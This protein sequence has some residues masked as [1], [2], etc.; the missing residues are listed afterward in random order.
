MPIKLN[1]RTLQEKSQLISD[2]HDHSINYES[3]EIYM[4]S[5]FQEEEEGVDFRMCTKLVKNLN[6]LFHMSPTEPILIHQLT[7]GGD[8]NYGMAMYD[9]IKSCS[10]SITVL[11][12]GHA[13]SMSSLIFQAADYRVLM[14]NCEFMIHEGQ[15]GADGTTKGFLSVAEQLKKDNKTMID[16]YLEK[17][18]KG[19]KWKGKTDNW[20]RKQLQTK[21]D[22]KQEWYLNS[23][24][25]V[26]Y[27]FADAVLGDENYENIEVLLRHEE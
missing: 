8:W 7:V 15:M 4:H 24:S 12:Y 6:I 14:P 26:E 19:E 27:G 20:I 21:M 2:I 5:A 18:K 23:R 25:A 3:R 11:A 9:A 22:L 16:I 17:T 10:S 1:G 13:G